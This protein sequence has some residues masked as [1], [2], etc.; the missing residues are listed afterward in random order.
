MGST[1]MPGKME[2]T[3]FATLMASSPAA[4]IPGRREEGG[5]QPTKSTASVPDVWTLPVLICTF[6][7][8]KEKKTFFTCRPSYSVI[9]TTSPGAENN[10]YMYPLFVDC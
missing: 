9:C 6:F 8:T 5:V 1:G 4:E 10:K 2:T 7:I 3:R